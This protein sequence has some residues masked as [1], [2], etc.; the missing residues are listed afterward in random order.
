M[1]VLGLMRVKNMDLLQ[2]KFEDN[3]E[4]ICLTAPIE[5]INKKEYIRYGRIYTDEKGNK[6]KVVAFT[7]DKSKYND[8]K[9]LVC[10]YIRIAKSKVE[11]KMWD[12][13][14]SL[15]D[16]IRAIQKKATG[17]H[18]KQFRH[19][20][21]IQLDGQYGVLHFGYT[22]YGTDKVL[23]KPKDGT[24]EILLDVDEAVTKFI[25]QYGLNE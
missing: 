23:F 24:P 19:E 4:V 25:E 11:I 12:G 22:E 17:N 5:N 20:V 1:I 6:K 2:R 8:I 7:E 13:K 16:F 14:Q 9:K 10:E 3:I 18:G 15:I 21:A